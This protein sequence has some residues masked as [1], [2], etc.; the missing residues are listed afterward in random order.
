MFPALQRNHLTSI[1]ISWD[2]HVTLCIYQKIHKQSKSRSH[3][4][5]DI[6]GDFHPSVAEK[7]LSPLDRVDS[8]M[9]DSPVE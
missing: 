4:V 1:S 6:P 2:T 5:T 8:Q 7:D 9:V 3:T